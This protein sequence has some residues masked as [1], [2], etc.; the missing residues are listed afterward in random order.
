MSTENICEEIHNTVAK[1]KIYKFPFNL[2]EIY[3][4][5]IY[6]LFEKYEEAH[7]TARIVRIGTHTGDDNLPVRL[8]EHFM[9]ENKDR[10]I[11]RK[12]IGRALINKNQY[13]CLDI[14]NKDYTS[15]KNKM[16]YNKLFESQKENIKSV[17]EDVSKYMRQ[18]FSFV[19]IKITDRNERLKYESKLIGTISNCKECNP[20][21]NWLGRFSPQIKIKESG[22]WLTQHLYKNPFS[23]QEWEEFKNKYLV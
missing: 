18:F 23:Y 9:K 4:N 20:S 10:S 15:G 3:M 21:A 13:T 1:L 8:K 11:F 14:W 17:E 19:I 5:G 7:G 2:E 16:E 12:N 22:L 6:V